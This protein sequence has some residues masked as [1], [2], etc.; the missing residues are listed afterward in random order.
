MRKIFSFLVALLILSVGCRTISDQTKNPTPQVYTHPLLTRWEVEGIP[1]FTQS[2]STLVINGFYLIEEKIIFFYTLSGSNAD[3][4]TSQNSIRIFDEYGD[5][6]NLTEITAFTNIDEVE[7]GKM[8]FSPRRTGIQE[9]YLSIT[10][11]ADPKINQKALV[12]KLI[13]SKDDDRLDR[14]FYGEPVNGAVINGYQISLLWSSAPVIPVGGNNPETP[15]GSNTPV[16]IVQPTSTI[17]VQRPA[18]TV[19]PNVNVEAEL[20]YQI[21]NTATGNILYVAIQLLTDGSSIISSNGEAILATPFAL[22]TPTPVN[23]SYPPPTAPYP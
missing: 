18:V 2:A 6:S 3:M 21:E 20:T 13:G 1:T 5:A 12:A 8:E 11:K 19:P 22:T 10:N 4:L 7:I 16:S 14:I 17:V 23:A 15:T 9:L